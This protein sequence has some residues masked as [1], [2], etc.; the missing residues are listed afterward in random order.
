MKTNIFLIIALAFALIIGCDQTTN[1]VEPPIQNT[2]PPTSS[3]IKNVKIVMK[4]NAEYDLAF[5]RLGYADSTQTINI[6]G[7]VPREIPLKDIKY[8]EVY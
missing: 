1:T 6:I 3:P 8:L 4:T 7:G 2:K 5:N